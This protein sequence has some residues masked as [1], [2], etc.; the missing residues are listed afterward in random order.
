[1]K[2]KFWWMVLVGISVYFGLGL[3]MLVATG[4]TYLYHPIIA[5]GDIQAGRKIGTL[6][7][8]QFMIAFIFGLVAGFWAI[9]DDH[10]K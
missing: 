4:T 2:Y 6:V 10:L 9:D 7:F 1:M 5:E 3:V 8:G